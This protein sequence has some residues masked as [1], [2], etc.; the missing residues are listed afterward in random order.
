M[1]TMLLKSWAFLRLEGGKIHK[2]IWRR[3]CLPLSKY[4]SSFIFSWIII[5]K[6]LR[7]AYF[8]IPPALPIESHKKMTPPL[9]TMKTPDVYFLQ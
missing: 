6:S 1:E 5:P 2:A 4:L 7:D 8:D 3:G 9:M